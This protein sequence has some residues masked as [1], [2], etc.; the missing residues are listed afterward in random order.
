LSFFIVTRP[1]I[2]NYLLK[3]L[4]CNRLVHPLETGGFRTDMDDTFDP[5]K[6]GMLFCLKC[7]GNGKLLNDSE[8]IEICPKCGGFGFIKKEKDPDKIKD[9][10]PI[11]NK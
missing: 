4:L 7:D 6:Y 1:S 3:R 5:Q 2:P 11:I 9:S 10:K 8:G